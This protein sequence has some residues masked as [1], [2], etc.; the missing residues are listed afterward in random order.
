MRIFLIALVGLALCGG[1]LASVPDPDMCSVMPP[2][3]YASPRLL[4]VPYT[5]GA[6]S[7]NI[8]IFVRA[9]DGSPIGNVLVEVILNPTC[10]D[11]APL[12]VCSNAVFTATTSGTGYCRI[13][14]KFGGCCQDVSS[15]IILA[16]GTPI[17]GY[18]IVVSPDYNGVD[19]NCRVEL[20]DF[21]YFAAGYGQSNV[22]CRNFDGDAAEN[23]A[24]ADFVVFAQ[25]YGRN[26]TGS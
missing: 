18:D 24:L 12:C 1:A 19:G 11:P 10:N 6:T 15:A 14:L 25:A 8:D 2:D 4:G 3:G 5:S 22:P 7:A 21:V 26:C 16:D 9:S 20:P 17:R 23:C 13:N